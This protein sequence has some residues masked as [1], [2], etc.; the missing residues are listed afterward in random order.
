MDAGTVVYRPW[1]GSQ[2]SYDAVP[3]LTTHI[4]KAV[5]TGIEHDGKAVL[6][7]GH[8]LV[9]DDN[10]WFATEA[11]AQRGL[12]VMLRLRM[13]ALNMQIEKAIAALGKADEVAA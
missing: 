3:E 8:G 6:R 13:Y 12:I 10:E 11:E 7:E 2:F 1:V 9:V 5:C 4:R